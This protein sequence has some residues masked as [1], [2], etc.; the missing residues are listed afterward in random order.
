MRI[1]DRQDQPAL[2]S[3][4][5][6]RIESSTQHQ[7]PVSS[8]PATEQLDKGSKRNRL[9][10]PGCHGAYE[11]HAAPLCPITQ[12][13]KKSTLAHP[14]RAQECDACTG[15]DQPHGM[16][17]IGLTSNQR[18][19]HVTNLRIKSRRGSCQTWLTT[20]RRSHEHVIYIQK[21]LTFIS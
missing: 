7:K 10:R 18:P 12:F 4:L 11:R 9:R 17:Q 14:G 1:V 21:T 6:Q 15:L 16:V 2:R 5:S 20:G 3:L 19:F 13:V 8:R